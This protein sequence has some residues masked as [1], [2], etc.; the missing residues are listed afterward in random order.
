MSDRHPKLVQKLAFDSS[1][2]PP[3]LSNKFLLHISPS[4]LIET[5]SSHVSYTKDAWDIQAS[6]LYLP[7][8]SNQSAHPVNY[9]HQN[10]FL[11]P[12]LLTTFADITHG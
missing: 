4:H 9:A 10:I 7:P 12:S 6:A 1:L 3:L 5:L 8:L 11:I 2:P